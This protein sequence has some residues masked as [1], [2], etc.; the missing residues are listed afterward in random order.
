[1]LLQGKTGGLPE[2]LHPFHVLL[3]LAMTCEMKAF[4]LEAAAKGGVD[5]A[6]ALVTE[7]PGGGGSSG[8]G[9]G[10]AAPPSVFDAAPDTVEACVRAAREGY[11]WDPRACTPR[12]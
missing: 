9:V 11:R 5:V 2:P 10:S 4:S 7:D 12:A 8:G 1:M 6:A 3:E